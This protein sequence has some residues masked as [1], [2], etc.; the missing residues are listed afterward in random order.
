MNFPPEVDDRFVA[1]QRVLV[2]GGRYQCYSEGTFIK[3][4]G[5]ASAHIRIDPIG[6]KTLRWSSIAEVDSSTP[7]IPVAAEVAYFEEV[8]AGKNNGVGNSA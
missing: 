3:C 1:G 2:T 6:V 4:T 5:K 8:L 7:F